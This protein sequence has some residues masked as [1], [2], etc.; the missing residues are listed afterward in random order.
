LISLDPSSEASKNILIYGFLD[1]LPELENW[2]E[3]YSPYDPK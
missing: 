3:G 1:K 2:T